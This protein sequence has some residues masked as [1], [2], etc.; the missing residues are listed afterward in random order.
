MRTEG[1]VLPPPRL[2]VLPAG[3][4]PPRVLLG[5]GSPLQLPTLI[6]KGRHLKLKPASPP[7]TFPL[8]AAG[9]DTSSSCPMP[10]T[11]PS[12]TLRPFWSPFPS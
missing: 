8:P 7:Q 5:P 1:R 11:S 3:P 2:H 10:K 12:S 9:L 4:V 6:R